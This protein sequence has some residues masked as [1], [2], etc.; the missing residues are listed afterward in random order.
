MQPDHFAT[1]LQTA[2]F[3]E[4]AEEEFQAFTNRESDISVYHLMADIAAGSDSSDAIGLAVSEGNRPRF[5]RLH[6]DS[7]WMGLEPL[8]GML[9]G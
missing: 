6:R 4:V 2:Q 3:G 7:Q 1:C 8:L 9:K 5:G